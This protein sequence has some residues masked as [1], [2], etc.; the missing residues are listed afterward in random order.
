[1]KKIIF[2]LP[3]LVFVE[4]LSQV[5]TPATGVTKTENYVYSREY[6][7]PVTSSS[8]AAKQ[9]Q[10]ITYYDGLGRP[11]Q[12]I[13]IKASPGGKDLVTKI[14]YDGFGRQD[15][16]HLPMPQTATTN[17]AVY[18]SIN[19][20][21][22]AP[23]YGNVGPYF[24]KKEIENSP[25][26][27]LRSTTAPG[28]WSG[29]GK[30]VALDYLANTLEDAVCK[31]VSTTTWDATNLMY[32]SS[33]TVAPTTDGTTTSGNYKPNI[34]YKNTVTDEDNNLTIEFKNGMGQ[35]LLVRKMEGTISLDTYYVYN[36]LNQLAYVIPPLAVQTLKPLAAGTNIATT[37]TALLNDVAYQYR[38]DSKNRLVEKRLPGKDWEYMAYDK[39]DRLV[40]TQ[41]ANQ[42]VLGR[43]LITKYDIFNR[44]VYTGT[45]A[46]GTRVVT[47][48]AFK[49]LAITESISASAFTKNGLAIYYT[50]SYFTDA[51]D[52]LSV[53]YYDTYPTGSP[54]LPTSV[55]NT[56]QP[57][58]SAT[59]TTVTS[60]G[61]VT[62]RS[63]KS[64][65]T[66]GFVKNINDD[67]WTKTYTWYDRKARAIGSHSINHLGGYTKSDNLLDFSGVPL[68]TNVYHKRLTSDTERVIK[69]RFVY[70]DQ[71]R[72]T[73]H[74][75]QVGSIA[76]QLLNNTTYN[77]LSQVSSKKVGTGT[78][79]DIN[80]TYNI[81]GW[82]T[83]VND[84]NSL[85]TDLFGY[86]LYYNSLDT[87]FAS[88]T[89]KHN[90]NIAQ[91]TWKSAYTGSDAKLRNY[92]YTYDGLNRLSTS[93]Y[94]TYA[95]TTG[96]VNFYNENLTYDV[97]GNISTLKRYAPPVSGTTATL[98]DDLVY[99]YQ[100]GNKSNRLTTINDNTTNSSGY[101]YVA[102]PT[103]IEYD[104]NG[105]MNKM[106][107]KGIS[108][109]TYNHLNLPVTITSTTS[110]T[111]NIY[112]ADGV[113]LKK[114]V[115]TKITDYLDGFQYENTI[116]QFVPTAEGYYDFVK[117]QY[118]YNYSDHLG[119]VRVSFTKNSAGALQVLEE[120]NYYPFGLKHQG[121]NTIANSTPSYQ[122]KYNGKELQETGMYDYG[123][124]FYMP[125][126]GRWGVV[127]PLA[128]KMRRFSTYT[129]AGDNPIR[130]IDPDGR[131]FINF[132]ENGNYTGT[133]KNN[134]W[135]NLWNGSK[136]RV[137][138]SDGSTKQKFRFA[139]PKNDVADIQSGKINKLEFVTEKQVRTLVRWS[140]AFDSKN[141]A[142]N[143]SLSERYDYIKKEGIG[144]GKMDFA[145]TQVPKMFPNAKPS[146]PTTN[147]SN[148]IFL[149]EGLAHNQNNF[150]NFLFGASGRAM[151]FT[152]TELSLGAHYNSV[153]N[154][155]TNG[156][157]SQLDSSDDQ[158][159]ISSGVLFS[160]KYNYGD[161]QTQI[162]VG[163]PTP[164]NTP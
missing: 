60:G 40:A 164:A 162:I 42:R 80:Y 58:L 1:M 107:D 63:T 12:T 120:N 59:P 26:D 64:L 157:S 118:I 160:D 112:R 159:S 143:R 50:N 90:G 43:W 20:S 148:T 24:T 134:W 108:N 47:Q 144:G 110:T 67:N 51:I 29:A 146:N 99:T 72:L 96:D 154:P 22:G 117:N 105:N 91:V 68:N 158:L 17:G 93:L 103:A 114:T 113:K 132:D 71:N 30:K 135:H 155:S 74:Y 109:I 39:L 94:R 66:A 86:Q 145:Y 32:T 124:R 129:Y 140:G 28:P 56:T 83:G 18:A 52:I 100:S 33:L 31:F 15:K 151:Q 45:V 142:S 119:N 101:P 97:N 48:N 46:R 55:Y 8:T 138:N 125:D 73:H 21:I 153:M 65:P 81:R 4:G 54:T 2:L 137:V 141:K 10:G 116:L 6:L 37:Q 25:L 104:A 126:I 161:M 147:T 152:E 128:E 111:T 70:D 127:D 75:H 57:T 122:Y 14:E 139:D 61:M 95:T 82:I 106:S 19:E 98:I 149:V 102:V 76:E 27:R 23:L 78:W 123:A 38:Y 36:D 115:G 35:T 77:A 131:K 85:G 150:G 62:S 163:T 13:A 87:R 34:L 88:A 79:Q 49:D 3:V 41:D 44:V 133:T 156:Y 11:K 5:T 53:N 92:T 89:A 136:G 16:E 9:I 7:A 130:Y 69:E 84:P 121:Y